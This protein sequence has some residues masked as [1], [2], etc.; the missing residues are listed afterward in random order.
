[1]HYYGVNKVDNSSFVELIKAANAN[2]QKKSYKEAQALLNQIGE[3]YKS[4]IRF[5]YTMGQLHFSSNDFPKAS[6][7][8][9]LI[10]NKTDLTNNPPTFVKNIYDRSKEQ[11]F[12]CDLNLGN[13]DKA[14]QHSD[15]SLK[16]TENFHVHF[17]AGILF[18]QHGDTNSAIKHYEKCIKINP[19]EKISYFNIGNCL[20]RQKKH[21]EAIKFFTEAL[22][23]DNSFKEA[24]NNR[25]NCLKDL[26]RFQMAIK[27]YKNALKIDNQYVAPMKNLAGIYELTKNFSS[28]LNFIRKIISI[29]P[30]NFDALFKLITLERQICLWRRTEQKDWE[31]GEKIISLSEKS[32]ALA[33]PSPFN[34]LN[35]KD[36]LQFHYRATKNYS[37]FR[38]KNV[39]REKIL[40]RKISK[41]DKIRVGY[42]SADFHTHATMHL[43]MRMLELH[44]M[45]QFEVYCFS[46]GP[47]LPDDPYQKRV[48]KACSEFID[49]NG[50]S[51]RMSLDIARSKKIDIALDLKGY[52]T[53]CRPEIFAMGIAPIQINYLGYPGSMAC[54]FMDYILAD[55]MVLPPEHEGYY[56]EKILR[57]SASYQVNDDMRKISRK[58]YN[59]K[60]AGLPENKFVFCNFNNSYK[61]GPTEFR[62][63]CDI[64][65]ECSGSILWLLETSESA[66]INLKN[67]MKKVGLEESRIY[68]AE[69]LPS[70]EHLKRIQNADLFLDTF[71]YNAHTTGSDA[72]WAGVPLLTL[73]GNSFPSRVGASLVNA[74][75]IPQLICKNKEEYVKLACRLYKNKKQMGEIKKTLGK[76]NKKLPLFATQKFVDELENHYSALVNH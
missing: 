16:N 51:D 30:T 38:V 9:A 48:K 39:K 62:L 29:E 2:I 66:K 17:R 49:L 22:K 4:D 44:N 19:K 15:S 45:N 33:A 26:R 43:M 14:K 7:I 3:N 10:S 52:T 1:M 61:I 58:R 12:L 23:I 65:K 46:F 20:Q 71:N 11:L 34:I 72:L 73:P 31:L 25:G 55:H 42:F 57:M 74:A 69:K 59:K 64:L 53:D 75:N 68:F 35:I 50:V 32:A 47:T 56:S 28:S 13:L 8:F 5:L 67:E 21:I 18:N 6:K 41:N 37:N 76:R 70:D 63:W 60:D 24:F 40:P 27:D 54:D 36:D